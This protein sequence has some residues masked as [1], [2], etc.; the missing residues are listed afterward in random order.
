MNLFRRVFTRD[1]VQH[2]LDA[3]QR[4]EQAAKDL[5]LHYETAERIVGDCDQWEP[6]WPEDNWLC[7]VHCPRCLPLGPC[8][9]HDQVWASVWNEQLRCQP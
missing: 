2:Q 5:Y 9:G 3:H 1:L 8:L 4:A 7:R 6:C